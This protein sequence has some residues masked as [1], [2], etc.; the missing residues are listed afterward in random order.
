MLK[1]G[2]QFVHVEVFSLHAPKK[3][4]RGAD[5]KWTVHELFAEAKRDPQ[6][7]LHVSFPRP[8]TVLY[9][10]SLDML[11]DEIKAIHAKSTD[12]VGRRLRQDASVLLAGVTSY[13]RDVF[14]YD[15]WKQATLNWLR[16]EFG[17]NLRTVIEHTDEAHPHLH[18]Y[19]VNP[20]GGNAK[21][22]HPGFRAGRGAKTPKEQRIAYN[23]AMRAFQDRFWEHVAGPS[24]MARLGPGR[25]RLSRVQWM[26]ERFTLSSQ[27]TLLQRAQEI[28]RGNG[29]R[30]R[31]LRLFVEKAL[32]EAE[33]LVKNLDEREARI[34]E[35]EASL[36]L[37]P[38]GDSDKT[39]LP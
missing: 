6:S 5:R 33:A 35:L 13:P 25:L 15:Y 39:D 38:K 36:G 9:G 18:F 14:G 8:P 31:Q 20:D 4:A 37:S 27:A 22:M 3:T 16:L 10:P 1:A 17:D 24:G 30:E 12:S 21:E 26:R 23:T 2:I 11:E 7:C 32:H 28:T 29:E 19:V 34:A